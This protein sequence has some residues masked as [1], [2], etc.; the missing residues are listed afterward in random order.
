MPRWD[1]RD[2][3]TWVILE[4][5]NT[6]I[7]KSPTNQR[8][9]KRQYNCW[10][11]STLSRGRHSKKFA[12]KLDNRIILITGSCQI[13]NRNNFRSCYTKKHKL[14]LVIYRYRVVAPPAHAINSQRTR[15]AI[16][17]KMI[18]TERRPLPLTTVHEY[19]SRR[20]QGSPLPSKDLLNRRHHPI[21]CWPL[22]LECDNHEMSE[23][24][25]NLRNRKFIR[26]AFH[27][28]RMRLSPIKTVPLCPTNHR[29]GLR[30]TVIIYS[31]RGLFSY[32]PSK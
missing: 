20:Q 17:S 21:H 3:H 19:K 15:P 22:P 11:K 8:T 6:Y 10:P 32:L 30:M 29:A 13:E 12:E 23:C 27:P 31:G 28:L 7:Y 4:D 25:A 26:G 18:R 9:K 5:A 14:S 16:N 24:N 1:A 2:R